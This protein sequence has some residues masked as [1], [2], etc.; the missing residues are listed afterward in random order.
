MAGWA[1]GGEGSEEKRKE[2]GGK[3][4]GKDGREGGMEGPLRRSSPLLVRDGDLVCSCACH[5]PLRLQKVLFPK[6][7]ALIL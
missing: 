7:F 3:G 1:L 4:K 2:T 5:A 6:I